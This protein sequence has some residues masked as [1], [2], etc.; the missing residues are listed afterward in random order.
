MNQPPFISGNSSFTS[1]P[2]SLYT[3]TAPRESVVQPITSSDN[4]EDQQKSE[5]SSNQQFTVP[6][7]PNMFMFYPGPFQNYR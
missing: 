1:S 3:P 5:T 7:Y 6:P 4:S 2:T